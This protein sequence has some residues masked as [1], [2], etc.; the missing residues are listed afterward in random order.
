MCVECVRVLH[1]QTLTANKGLSLRPVL[2]SRF[3]IGVR[4]VGALVRC[5]AS[6]RADLTPSIANF[7]CVV[8]LFATVSC[9]CS[10]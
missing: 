5:T 3:C 8:G 1:T 4:T 2:E 7:L 10:K 9:A 6:A